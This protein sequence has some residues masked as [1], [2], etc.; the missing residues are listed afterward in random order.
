MHAC[1][2]A[3]DAMGDV[4]CRSSK[5]GHL[6]DAVRT[7]YFTYVR[8]RTRTYEENMAGKFKPSL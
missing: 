2:C 7:M 8:E 6:T 4:R 5:D 1:A 3:C